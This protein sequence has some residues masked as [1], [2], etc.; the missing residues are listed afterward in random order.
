MH[1]AVVPSL[2][3]VES[4]SSWLLNHRRTGLGIFFLGG[5]ADM[6]LPDWRLRGSGGMLPREILKM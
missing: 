2:M 4:S 1:E 3:V 5:G 6:G